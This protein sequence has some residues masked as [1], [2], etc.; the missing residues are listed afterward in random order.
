MSDIDSTSPESFSFTHSLEVHTTAPLGQA[1]RGEW[2]QPSGSSSQ[3]CSHIWK[4]KLLKLESISFQL[5]EGLLT[6]PIHKQR[7]I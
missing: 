7:I 1:S 5:N 2:T 3:S 6:G 4:S